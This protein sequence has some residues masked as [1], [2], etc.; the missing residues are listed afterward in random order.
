MLTS[1]VLCVEVAAVD[2]AFGLA[3]A[4]RDGV[5]GAHLDEDADAEDAFDGV[6][7]GVAD[8]LDGGHA[9]VEDGLVDLDIDLDVVQAVVRGSG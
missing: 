6:A 1:P 8:V 7:D 5:R 4:S 9:V 3:F 2:H